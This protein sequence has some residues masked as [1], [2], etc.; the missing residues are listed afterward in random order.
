[1][2]DKP[3]K[4]LAEIEERLTRLRRLI[5]L[6]DKPHFD[7]VFEALSSAGRPMTVREIADATALDSGSVRVVLYGDS[8]MFEKLDDRPHRWRLIG[9]EAH[10]SQGAVACA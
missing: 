3:D 7:R 4:L 8:S 6:R 5:D 9:Q 2:Q 1:M 10:C